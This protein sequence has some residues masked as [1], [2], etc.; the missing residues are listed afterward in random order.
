M[1]ISVVKPMIM[2]SI[3]TPTTTVKLFSGL[4]I[5]IA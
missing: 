1:L 5:L 3:L 4:F 2:L